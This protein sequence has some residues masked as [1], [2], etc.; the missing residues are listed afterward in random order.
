MV[1]PTPIA[2]E[3]HE[4]KAIVVIQFP[5]GSGWFE[6]SHLIHFWTIS[7][8]GKSIGGF[9]ETVFLLCSL[10]LN[11]VVGGSGVGAAAGTLRPHGDKPGDKGQLLVVGR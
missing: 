7:L 1:F 6:G 5:F 8:K 3:G 10:C 9:R 4:S 2:I 11:V